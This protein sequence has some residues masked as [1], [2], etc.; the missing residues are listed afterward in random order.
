MGRSI[1]AYD[2]DPF[3]DIEQDKD[4]LEE[5]ETV[6]EGGCVKVSTCISILITRIIN[7]KFNEM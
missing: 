6:L 7:I 5:N 3:A 1:P 2:E 4:V